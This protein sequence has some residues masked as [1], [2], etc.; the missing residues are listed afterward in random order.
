MNSVQETY[1]SPRTDV[2]LS[3]TLVWSVFLFFN[4]MVTFRVFLSSFLFDIELLVETAYEGF[5]IFYLFYR[6]ASRALA[7]NLRANSLEIYLGL[8]FFL[9]FISALG[10]RFTFGQPIFYGLMTSREF[11]LMYGALLVYDLLRR[12]VVSIELVERLFV[13]TAWFNLILFYG[14][15]LLT[16]PSDFRDTGLAGSNPEKGDSVYY[17]FNMAYMF[18]GSIYYFVKGFYQHKYRFFLFSGLFLFYI[19][20]FR[21]DRTSMAVAMAAMALFFVTGFHFKRQVLW[22]GGAGLLLVAG[23]LFASTF[24]PQELEQY[25][26]MFVEALQLAG[27]S[28]PADGDES[29]RIYEM[30]VATEHIMKSPFIGN[31]KLSNEWAEGG[32]NKFLGF[33]YP[34][35]IGVPG[36]VFIYGIPGAI[37][38]YGQFLLA[39]IYISRIKNTKRNVFLVSLKFFMLALGLDA[40]TNG[41]VTMYA[42]Q[43]ITALVLIYFFYQKDRIIKNSPSKWEPNYI[44]P[45]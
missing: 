44:E 26:D 29:I 24:F 42:A 21:L 11:Y 27:V 43:T 19:L 8:M 30:K 25:S 14:L 5:L 15:S 6:L 3:N 37:I 16:N 10:A 17:R 13:F 36:Q 39:G 40:L 38:L 28:K 2:A 12:G 4:F 33:F 32:Y 1:V 41:Y 35:D 9:P 7:G 23:W 45:E 22:I 20:F 34:S 31:G 18:F